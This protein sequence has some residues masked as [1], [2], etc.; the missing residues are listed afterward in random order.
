M[1][2]TRP[3]I[4]QFDTTIS[5]ISDPITV[6][7]AGV[8]QANVDIG[9]LM[10][11]ANGL[12]SNVAVYW[13]ESGNTFVTAFTNDSGLATA[14]ITATGY[15]TFTTGTLIA[16]GVDVLAN[17]GALADTSLVHTN[18]IAG[19]NA[20]IVTANTALKDYADNQITTANTALKNYT[21]NQITTANTALKGY[22]DYQIT[23][24]NT[25]LK[26]YTDYQ[27]TAANVVLADYVDTRFTNLVNGAPAALDTLYEISTSLGNNAS[28]STTLLSAIS[29]S[30]AAIVTA[31]TA[32]KG[33]VDAADS[34]IT[35]A[36][37]ANAASQQ[38]QIATLQSQVYSNSNVNAYLSS[39][40]AGNITINNGAFALTP[41]G[42]G[43]VT[44]GSATSIP[45]IVTDVYGRIIS[46]TS[47]AVSTTIS[48]AGTTGSGAVSGG[49]TLT[50]AGT[51]G[52]T[53]AANGSAITIGTPQDLRISA[54]PSFDN[55]S[56]T[57]STPSTSINTG[58]LTVSGGVGITG[59]V[60]IGGNI[61]LIGNVT[62]VSFSGNSGSFIGNSTTGY[63]ALYAG[64][65]TGYTSLP[66]TPFQIATN[67]NTY[68]Q[69]NQQ[70]INTGKYASSDYVVTS[71][72]GT[73]S[74]FY[75]DYGI[76][77][78]TFY[79]PELGL[80]AIGPNDT[81][82]LGV[83]YNALGPYTGNVGNV[84]ISSSNGRIKFASG[85]ADTADVVAEVAGTTLAVLS[86]TTSTST[87]TGA[88]TVAGGVGIAGN[89]YVGTL[90]TTSG[91][92]WAANGAPIS[93]GGG[94]GITFTT[95]STN[96]SF[97]NPGDQW[98]N[99]TNDVLYEYQN[100]GTGSYWIDVTS[101]QIASGNVTVPGDNT[102]SPFLLMGA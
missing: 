99:T 57:A 102:I 27:I 74:T 23:T 46:L 33:Y 2:L 44:V 5:S 60:W 38:G 88:L 79:Y 58:A 1:A 16:K 25:A 36:W 62:T 37:T 8:A 69:L 66:S 75:G 53:A 45:T 10:N 82:L 98:Y 7:K 22:T 83:G 11:R 80:T 18:A 84:V 93:T 63:G 42:P 21:D 35:V 19:A 72:N 12:V 64:I 89:A 94:A 51:Y 71:D 78:S 48:L 85:G 55:L 34:A 81:Y 54:S 92:K 95:A 41:I 100:V 61:S 59:N 3:R 14:N 28:L 97:P 49:G 67:A 65:P 17:I 20:A 90:Y 13:S 50:F 15:A 24:A 29:G 47:N 70:N 26:N 30:N 56:V 32:L 39:S 40:G 4:Q 87:T 31:N 76:A 9:F 43:P 52:V 101:P 91:I 86:T 68:S 6:L 96:P 77:S 73:D